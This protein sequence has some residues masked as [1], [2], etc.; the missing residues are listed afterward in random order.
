MAGI[1]PATTRIVKL[2]VDG[3]GDGRAQGEQTE[4][5]ATVDL[6]HCI[7]QLPPAD[8]SLSLDILDIIY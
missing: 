2:Q 6:E 3:R 5:G 1:N 8:P 7:F 4:T